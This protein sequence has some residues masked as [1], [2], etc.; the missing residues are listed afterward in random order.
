MRRA[1]VRFTKVDDVVVDY[2]P[3]R[4]WNESADDPGQAPAEQNAAQKA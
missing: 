2:H 3:S 1:G 4:L